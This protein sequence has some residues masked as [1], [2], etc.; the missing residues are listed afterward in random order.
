MAK[1]KRRVPCPHCGTEIAADA[2]VC[3]HCG[4]DERT[5][6]SEQTYMDGIDLPD[7]SE[8]DE[9]VAKEFGGKQDQPHRPTWTIVVGVALLAAFVLLIL[10]GIF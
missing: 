5:G 7:E 8:Y 10:R 3:A 1:S 2:K 9:M 6:W 4:S